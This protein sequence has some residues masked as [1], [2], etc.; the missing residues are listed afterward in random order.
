MT[1]VVYLHV[2]A[3]KTGTT[4]LQDRLWLNAARLA[5][6]RVHVPTGS[7]F[8]TSSMF[9][10]RA[11]LDLLGQDW[12][13]A[14]GHAAGAWPQ[15]ARKVR[16]LD[17]TVIVSHEILAPAPASKVAKAMNDL[18]GSEVHIVYS[19]RDLGRQLPAAW[20][21]SIKQGRKWTF[22]RFLNKVETGKPWFYRALDL[23]TVLSTWGDHLAPDHIHVVT[24][25]PKRQA[26]GRGEILWL[27]FCEAFGIDPA[28][29]P[30]D[31]ERANP[32]LG[33]AETQLIRQ[34]N[35][36]LERSVRREASYDLLI[37]DLLA[38]RELVNRESLPVRL[39][40]QRFGWADEQA[41]LWIDWLEGSGVHVIGDPEDLRPVRPP[42]DEKWRNPDR[43]RAKP[44]LEAA[45]D[46]LEAMTR[47]AARRPDPD[48]QLTHLVRQGA[49][50]LRKR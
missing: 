40:P 1:R 29:A 36:R 27:R 33:I 24:V 50:R 13:G 22:R 31:S 34:L 7:R 4:Y 39:P 23:P 20:Q 14:R 10:F 49:D 9:H 2:G 35:S 48:R 16:R 6:Q 44:V 42:E 25:P 21:E 26:T 19:A 37:R 15:L 41:Q 45:L 12:G 8:T 18:E 46:A 11:A 17:G 5:E 38:Q 43:A 30:L 47:E 28:W 32:S 3:P